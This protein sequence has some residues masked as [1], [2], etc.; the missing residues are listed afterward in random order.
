MNIFNFSAYSDSRINCIVCI[1]SVC[2]MQISNRICLKLKRI[3]GY[4]KK[5]I[6]SSN[7]DPCDKKWWFFCNHLLN[8]SL[9]F[10]HTKIITKVATI[11]LQETCQK[12]IERMVYINLTNHVIDY[13]GVPVILISIE[14]T[15][16][17]PTTYDNHPN[18]IPSIPSH[19]AS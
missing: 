1:F 17:L 9:W 7:Q 13:W 18:P 2:H 12:L 19:K 8:I 14:G 6:A 16:R 10:N 15:L 5:C 4:E 3:S 11:F